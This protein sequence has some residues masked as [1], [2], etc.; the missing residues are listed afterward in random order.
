MLLSLRKH[1]CRSRLS[2]HTHAVTIKELPAYAARLI[3]R[4]KRSGVARGQSGQL[5]PYRI[6]SKKN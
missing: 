2:E 4:A 1:V 5:S 3:P 6:V